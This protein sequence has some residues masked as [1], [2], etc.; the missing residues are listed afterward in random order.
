[1][2]GDPTT[3]LIHESPGAELVVVGSHGRGGLGGMILGSVS[4]TL[5]HRAHCPVAVVRSQ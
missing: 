3:A 1:M 2:R 5:L 4:Q